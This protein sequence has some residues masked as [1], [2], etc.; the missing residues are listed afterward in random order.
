MIFNFIMGGYLKY[1]LFYL[2]T[3][4]RSLFKSV[5]VPAIAMFTICVLLFSSVKIPILILSTLPL[6]IIGI[7][8]GLFI[9]GKNFGFMSIV[10]VLSLSGM[11]I[12]NVI[13]M[14]DEINYEINILKKNKFS[15]LIDSAVSRIRSVSL[16][17]VTTIFGMVPLLWDPLYGDMA[18]TIIFGLFVST[19]LTLFIFPVIYGTVYKIYPNYRRKRK[20]KYIKSKN[21]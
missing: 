18:A 16:A 14:L 8:P 3:F 11:M 7:A 15:A 10:G 9:T 4:F 17:A 19:L 6:A 13:V 12:K 2:Q 5:P 20:P 1:L 21:I